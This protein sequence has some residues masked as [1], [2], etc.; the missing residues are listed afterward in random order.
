MGGFETPSGSLVKS[1][2]LINADG[3]V[4]IE[5]FKNSGLWSNKLSTDSIPG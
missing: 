3:T 2:N 1:F 5:N 4:G